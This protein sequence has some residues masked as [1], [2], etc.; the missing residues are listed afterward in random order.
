MKEEEK[1]RKRNNEVGDRNE[2]EEE[3]REKDI[4]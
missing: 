2:R 4:V 1:K 3:I